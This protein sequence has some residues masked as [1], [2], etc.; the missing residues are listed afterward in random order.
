VYRDIA[1]IL[2][3]DCKTTTAKIKATP[4]SPG[5]RLGRLSI[6]RSMTA[7]RLHRAEGAIPYCDEPEPVGAG[8]LMQRQEAWMGHGYVGAD[9]AVIEPKLIEELPRNALHWRVVEEA[10]EG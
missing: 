6:H 8:F 5:L 7:R 3:A 2:L 4:T 1:T 10:G 9:L